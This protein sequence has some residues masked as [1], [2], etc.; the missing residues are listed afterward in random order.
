[1]GS[2]RGIAAMFAV[3]A[4]TIALLSPAAGVA[5]Q[6]ARPSAAGATQK[7]GLDLLREL[8]PGNLV[9]S[10]NSVATAL[11]MAGTGARGRTAEEMARTLHL[12]DPRR[13]S[14]LGRLQRE[15]TE[16]W[17]LAAGGDPEAPAL[18]IANGLFA[19]RGFALRP[20][21]T[22]GL[23]RDFAATPRLV[24]FENDMPGALAAINGWVSEQTNGLIPTLFDDLDPRTKLVLG[25]ALYLDA[26][27]AAPF[28]A[29]ATA[30]GTFRN[31]SGR[32]PAEFMNGT[33]T[34]AYTV[35][36]GF[37]AV[38]LGYRASTLSML[39][40]LPDTLRLGAF[41]D[42]LDARGLREIVRGLRPMRV[43]LSLPRFEIQLQ[44][45]LNVVLARLG[46]PT[47]FGDGANFSGMT[48]V[49]P[50]R[51]GEVAHAARIKV[52][53][54]GTVAGAAT[55]IG[56]KLVSKPA[57]FRADHPFLFFLRDSETGAVLFAGRVV[58]PAGTLD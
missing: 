44:R 58:D 21:F 32:G 8:S 6:G 13:F 11:A 25:N 40:V 23:Q 54:A 41:V 57:A 34:V 42:R 14:T 28:N 33:R 45:K 17:S 30:S 27:W 36:E 38:E 35:G 43:D 48:G 19:Q 50:L 22:T 5:A 20:R 56:I 12:D 26:R 52:D 7:L 39:V 1:M 3:A 53:E 55:G 51:I 29:S 9:V 18:N 4:L 37:K 47:A 31:R 16:A 49:G 46:M 24:D 2:A 15:L 10:P